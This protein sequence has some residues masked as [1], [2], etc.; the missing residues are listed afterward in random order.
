MFWHVIFESGSPGCSLTGRGNRHV[1]LAR[2]GGSPPASLSAASAVSD[3][4]H[5][6]LDV[7][8]AGIWRH[9][10]ATISAA[11][12]WPIPAAAT[13]AAATAGWA[14][15]LPAPAAPTAAAAGAAA[16]VP[17]AT[18]Q[19]AAG[20][21]ATH[22][23]LHMCNHFLMFGVRKLEQGA[24]SCLLHASLCAARDAGDW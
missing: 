22:A 16:A 10:P 1:A 20:A 14:G 7:H 11:W 2:Q 13:H 4:V 9:E 19:P 6:S 21:P 15:R 5:Q 3:V 12:S 18:V 17:A 8:I 24:A 23:D